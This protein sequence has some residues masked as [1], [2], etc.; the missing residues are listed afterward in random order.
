MGIEKLGK[1]DWRGISRNFVTT[2]TPTQVASHAQKYYLRQAATLNKKKQRRSSLFDVN[3]KKKNNSETNP[4]SVPFSQ[5]LYKTS[6]YHYEAHHDANLPI[7]I[8]L[9]A[10]S[11]QNIRSEDIQ[12][13]TN[14]DH[15]SHRQSPARP[16][17]WLYG[18]FDSQMQ[19]S[20]TTTRTTTMP[21]YPISRE[22]S[23]SSSVPDLELKLSVVGTRSQDQ[24]KKSSSD[25]L[26]V[27]PVVSVI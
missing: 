15:Q 14:Y 11:E 22:S 23:S 10:S 2:R 1:G 24:N 9:T 12:E 8:D 19:E 5:H 3:G 6:S 26:L 25:S 27:G 13:I 20:S 17:G 16:S 7:V 21:E 4:S 18:F